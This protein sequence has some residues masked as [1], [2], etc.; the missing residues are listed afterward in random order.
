MQS[1]WYKSFGLLSL[2][3]FLT[4]CGSDGE[5]K[6]TP[7]PTAVASATLTSVVAG[8]TVQLNGAGS[9]APDNGT[10]T[11]QW[12]LTGKPDLSSAVL[13]DAT[14]VNPTFVA[15]LPGSYVAELRVINSG[16]AISQS[17]SVTITATSNIPVAIAATQRNELVNSW[18]QLDGSNSVPPTGGDAALLT[19]EWT[20]SPPSGTDALDDPTSAT[21]GFSPTVEGIYRA[22]L[23]VSYGEQVSE[24]LSILINVSKTNTVP[25]A[26]AGGTYTTVL[27]ETITLDGSA[28][29][30]ADGDYLNYRW[31]LPNNTSVAVSAFADVKPR[32]SSVQLDNIDSAT[33]D[34]TPDV[35]GT[36][37]INLQVFDGTA[38]STV[39]TATVTVT[40]PENHLNTAPVAALYDYYPVGEGNTVG[41]AEVSAFGYAYFYSGSY[42]NDGDTLTYKWEWVEYPDAFAGTTHSTQ[43]WLNGRS[44]SVNIPFLAVTGSYGAYVPVEGYYTIRLTVNDGTVDSEPIEQTIHVRTGANTRPSAVAKADIMALLTNTEAWFDGSESSDPQDGTLGL[45]YQWNWVYTPPGSAA[46]LNTPTTA[47]TSFTPDLPGPYIAEL[48]VTDNDGASSKPDH[49]NYIAATATINAKLTNNLPFA[50]FVSAYGGYGGTG[51]QLEY[52]SDAGVY[53]YTLDKLTGSCSHWESGERSIMSGRIGITGSAYDVDGDPLFYDITLDA[54][55]GSDQPPSF[56]GQISTGGSFGAAIC[57]QIPGDY[58]YTLQVSDG[59]EVTAA[60][61]LT[62]RVEDFPADYTALSI[63]AVISNSGDII[64]GEDSSSDFNTSTRLDKGNYTQGSCGVGS[65][66]PEYTEWLNGGVLQY[67][68]I[69]A[70]GQDYTISEVTTS[71][72]KYYPATDGVSAY[73]GDFEGSAAH[74]PTFIDLPEKVNAGESVVFG[75]YFP[76]LP[77]K[78]PAVAGRPY[79]IYSFEWS[80]V[81]PEVMTVNEAYSSGYS[82]GNFTRM[83][84]I[85][86]PYQD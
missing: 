72:T 18:V 25:V 8:S 23:K 83:Q 17:S 81:V 48:I 52:D 35:V 22:V 3:I 39:S 31:V 77:A 38:L 24:P 11:Y 84:T 13:S 67:Y 61:T 41:E 6:T 33:I 46:V 34:F 16:I 5:D 32:G 85:D 58:K 59:S 2:M 44:N 63:D 40:K 27:G 12:T 19:Y 49:G 21:P 70:V 26:N 53:T 69:T 45:Q 36:Y 28:S 20:L 80:F 15:D 68:R 62:I 29:S 1:R 78:G 9:S 64:I 71:V 73:Y 66:V 14:L 10:L 86:I 56:T 4:A 55:A 37:K 51:E 79:D 42:D 57:N 47:R 75:V 74:K 7:I 43:T 50:R 60:Q 76:A 65:C 54:P 30:D 82:S